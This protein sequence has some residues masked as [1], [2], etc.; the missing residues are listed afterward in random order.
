MGL[1]LPSSDVI[2]SERLKRYRYIVCDTSIYFND[3]FGF[4]DKIA[5]LHRQRNESLKKLEMICR[6]IIIL[7]HNLLPEVP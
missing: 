1:I 4:W 5:Q 7:L 2:P 6:V 3:V